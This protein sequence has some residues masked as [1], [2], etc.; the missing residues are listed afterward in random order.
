MQFTRFCFV[1]LLATCSICQ[2][3][4][5]REILQSN[6]HLKQLETFRNALR[7]Q[8][9]SYLVTKFEQIKIKEMLKQLFQKK[10]S[11]KQ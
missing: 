6:R 10:V 11:L 9:N 2:G 8:R 1:C 3:F 4:H 5:T 7:L